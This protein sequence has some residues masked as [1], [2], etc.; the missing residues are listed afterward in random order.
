MANKVGKSMRR[1]I[2]ILQEVGPCGRASVHDHYQE[3]SRHQVSKYLD[4][5]TVMGLVTVE[6]GLGS[7]ANYSVY[8]AV[9]NWEYLADARKTKH[10]PVRNPPSR[11]FWSGISSVF[12]A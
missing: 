4:R 11:T 9:D 2:R 12:G 10:L 8:K 3:I 1:I 5:A 7:K 6:K